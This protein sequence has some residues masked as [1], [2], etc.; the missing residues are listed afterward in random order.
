VPLLAMRSAVLLFCAQ[1]LLCLPDHVQGVP[2]VYI[3]A[4]DLKAEKDAEAAVGTYC[5]NADPISEAQQIENKKSL[6]LGLG[7]E[8][9]IFVAANTT[10]D[11]DEFG[12]KMAS[13]V[14]DKIGSQ[15]F[16]F[17]L[18]ACSFVCLVVFTYTAIPA[19]KFCR[20]CHYSHNTPT[21][22][23][24]AFIVPVVI[25]FIV[26]CVS[27]SKASVGASTMVDG[28]NNVA[29]DSAKL[30]NASF[31]GS[32]S[33][34]GIMKSL[35]MLEEQDQHMENTSFFVNTT[36]LVLDGTAPL[37]LMITRVKA[38]LQ[39]VLN[40]VEGGEMV[41]N[42]TTG[43]NWYRNFA[44][45]P[46]KSAVADV[47]TAIDGSLATAMSNFRAQ[48]YVI[49]SYEKR[50]ESQY[51]LRDTADNILAM[52]KLFV[53]GVGM[54]SRSEDN[55]LEIL[56]V[57]PP[58]VIVLF[59]GAFLALLFAGFSTGSL[60]VK[61]R[62]SDGSY[63]TMPHRCGCASW[64]CTLCVA[65][66][67][68]I[69]GGILVGAS[70]PLAAL[71]LIV[72][73]IDGQ[74]LMDMAP[75]LGLNTSS[76][77]VKSQANMLDMCIN[78]SNSSLDPLIADLTIVEDDDG[79]HITLTESNNKGDS[80]MVY[81]RYM[82]LTQAMATQSTTLLDSAQVTQ[83][84]GYIQTHSPVQTLFLPV[85]AMKSDSSYQNLINTDLATAFNTSLACD[86][87]GNGLRDFA[88]LA[89]SQCSS[90]LSTLL[91]QLGCTGTDDTSTTSPPG[92]PSASANVCSAATDYIALA[93]SFRSH[94]PFKCLEWKNA[95]ANTL[96][97]DLN[98]LN[99]ADP[100]C[101]DVTLVDCN[102][103]KYAQDFVAVAAQTGYLFTVLDTVVNGTYTP[104]TDNLLKLA[105]GLIV[106][107][108]GM[109]NDGL[110]CGFL[111]PLW[112]AVVDSLCY[113][114]A[115]GMKSI[116]QGYV[117]T[118]IF[119]F[120]FGIWM[121]IIWRV[122]IDNVNHSRTQVHNDVQVEYK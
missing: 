23:K 56:K 6:A 52:K 87:N 101:D 77:G 102:L 80:A 58:L 62:L 59:M 82:Q 113:Q 60:L 85:E 17:F 119:L 76:P 38:Y 3:S 40:M 103:A 116:G 100:V 57:F 81:M 16:P 64:G 65:M 31:K 68:L 121:Y 114:G 55:P 92:A 86:D 78:N 28:I 90:S 74:M 96:T 71:C 73:D 8:N 50:N 9:F 75:G 20:L 84:L 120:L 26:V 61:E 39:A 14:G 95:A 106:Q 89:S 19:F 34:S 48:V 94:A 66:P 5:G 32:G 24:V 115:W 33:T 79:S 88:Q 69:L 49:N 2:F 110:T 1:C 107:P 25:V 12:D 37:P 104:I 112:Q 43:T 54:F 109:I 27:V 29:C 111:P 99:P 108:S 51:S 11:T 7:D 4:E 122:T 42:M 97:C 118:G 63:N 15:G 45:A 47:S 83:M 18:A 35:R 91:G 36:T 93:S 105:M 98:T 53:K 30:I 21:V 67:A 41:V 72:D 117:L 10:N 44:S 70:L 46:F 13:M 22:L